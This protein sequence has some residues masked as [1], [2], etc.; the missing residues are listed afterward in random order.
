MDTFAENPRAVV[1]GNSPPPETAIDRATLTI[2]ALRNFLNNAPVIQTEDEARDGKKAHD[3]AAAALRSVE[4][5][6]KGKVD[7]LNAEVKKINGEYHKLHNADKKTGTWDRLLSDLRSRLTAYARELERQ[8]FAAEER[9]RIEAEEAAEAARRAAE[10][11]AE[12]RD[13]AAAGV[14]DVDLAEAM[15]AADTTSQ[16]ALRKMW[17]AR[18]A[19]KETKVRIVGGSANAMSLKDHETLTISDWR[20]AIEDIGLTD[21]MADA[22]VK[23][24]R[25]YRKEHH[26]LPRGIERITERGL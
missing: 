1:G 14:C 26:K 6:R 5:E 9:A 21:E 19:E 4:F 13:A 10:A 24:A 7:P 15:E 25:A 17:T 2:E 20:A 11:E 3:D 12:A 18:R 8:R 23:G 16:E 22:I